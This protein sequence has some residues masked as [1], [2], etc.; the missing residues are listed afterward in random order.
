MKRSRGSLPVPA[1]SGDVGAHVAIVR[2]M[3]MTTETDGSP[4]QLSDTLSVDGAGWR[5]TESGWSA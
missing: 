3:M 1:V 5:L 4:F 2:Q